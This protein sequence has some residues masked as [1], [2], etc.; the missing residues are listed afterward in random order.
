VSL[1]CGK[2][3]HELQE[4]QTIAGYKCTKCDYYIR[5]GSIPRSSLGMRKCPRCEAE[6]KEI[7]DCNFYGNERLK[8]KCHNCGHEWVELR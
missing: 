6:G 1:K 7:V 3:G 8:Y 2:E 5:L 4:V